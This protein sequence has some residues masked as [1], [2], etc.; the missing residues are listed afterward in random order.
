M[1][2]EKACHWFKMSST[3]WASNLDQVKEKEAHRNNLVQKL[4]FIVKFNKWSIIILQVV[5][6]STKWYSFK[7]YLV[8]Q[9]VVPQVILNFK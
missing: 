2:C 7:W 5:L 6:D 8:Y 4:I 3:I 1:R 9:M